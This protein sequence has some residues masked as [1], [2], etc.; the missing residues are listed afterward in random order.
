[1]KTGKLPTRFLPALILV[2]SVLVQPVPARGTWNFSLDG[3]ARYLFSD[4]EDH[5]ANIHVAGVSVRKTF[6]DRKGDRFTVFGLAEAEDNFSEIMLHE[7]YG[8]YKGPLGS[9]NVTAG[10]FGLPWGLL[11]GFSAS[12]LLYNMPHNKLLGMDV[13]SGVKVSGVLG[14]VDY[15]VSFT[16]GYGPHHT[17]HDWGYGLGMARIGFTPGD[18]EEFSIGMSGAAGKSISA[19]DDDSHDESDKNKAVHRALVGMDATCYLGR[20]LGR[21]EIATGRVDHEP[22]TTAFAAVDFA[23]LPR[24]DLNLSANLVWHGSEYED[25]WFV[26][27]TGKPPW[28]TIRGGYRYAGHSKSQHEVTLQLYHLFSM[29]F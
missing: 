3:D 6:S 13:D 4:W 24:L 26:G 29:S 19:H 16:Q 14:A 22:M 1:L 27:F 28:F 12:R 20:W 23:L 2:V 8:L 21:V 17:P 11:P 15:A 5:E 18:T 10:R 9:W 25:E 7:V